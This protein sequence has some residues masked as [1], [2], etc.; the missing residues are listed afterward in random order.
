MSKSMGR[1]RDK[2]KRFA[3]IIIVVTG[4]SMLT[5]VNPAFTKE[6]KPTERDIGMVIYPNM[7][8]LGYTTV[9]RGIT[10]AQYCSNSSP[11]AIHK[12][13]KDIFKKGIEIQEGISGGIRYKLLLD[14]SSPVNWMNSIKFIEIYTDA[15]KKACNTIVHFTAQPEI[16]KKEE[17]KIPEKVKH[18]E[19]VKN[20]RKYIGA[21]GNVN[22]VNF[23][24]GPTLIIWPFKNIAFQA[25]YGVG[26]FKSFEARGFYRFDSSKRLN[27]Y[28]GAGYLHVEK[29]VS[30]IGVSTTIKE[31]SFTVFG[32]IELPVYKSL[33]AYVDI[34]GTPMQIETDVTNGSRNA[35]VTVSYSPVTIGMGLVFYI[36]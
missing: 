1:Q 4:I 26:T 3:G 11:A 7:Q 30:A 28:L 23:S 34:T 9:K 12:Y 13:Y 16:S 8:F 33:V 31:N 21:G 29:D 27:L 10:L 2:I 20:E 22:A 35:K 17:V 36:F 25:S 5:L 19:L 6:K 18:A 15:K 14:V 24:A 32:G